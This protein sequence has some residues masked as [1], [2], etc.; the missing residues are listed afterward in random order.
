M[1]SLDARYRHEHGAQL[2]EVAVVRVLDLDHA[3]RVEAA[4]HAAP[5]HLQL[6]PRAAHRE[7]HRRLQLPY[8]RPPI[9]LF[10]PHAHQYNL[11]LGPD[12]ETRG[13]RFK[14]W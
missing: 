6:L 9:A 2:D 13:P 12:Y 10:I 5:A 1:A 11:V 8:L 4:T 7:R 14:S 3:P